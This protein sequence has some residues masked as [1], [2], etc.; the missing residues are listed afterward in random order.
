VGCGD[1]FSCF[2]T[3]FGEVYMSGKADYE[4]SSNDDIDI[5]SI[6]YPVLLELEI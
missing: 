2:V 4:R 1:N 6:P 5:Y 3:D